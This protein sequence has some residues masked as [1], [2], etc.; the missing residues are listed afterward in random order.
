LFVRTASGLPVLFDRLW[1]FEDWRSEEQQIKVDEFM[2]SDQLVVRADLPGGDPDHDI[3]LTVQDGM[4][5]IHGQRR[6]ET[7]AWEKGEGDRTRASWLADHETFFRR[8]LPTIGVEFDREM[9]TVFERSEVVYT[10]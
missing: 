3:E 10:E 1:P 4:L 2:D 9:A 8:Y 5:H 6:Q 7:V